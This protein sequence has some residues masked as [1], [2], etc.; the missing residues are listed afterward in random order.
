M[1]AVPEEELGIRAPLTTRRAR[2]QETRANGQAE[3]FTA[4][5]GPGQT[6]RHVKEGRNAAIEPEGTEAESL[7]IKNPRT[8]GAKT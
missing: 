8:T 5:L 1:G 7:L 4:N 3:N 6:V 2:S